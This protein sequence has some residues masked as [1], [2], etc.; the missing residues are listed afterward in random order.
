[1]LPQDETNY[2]M[3]NF[4]KETI[5]SDF[6]FS[7]LVINELEHKDIKIPKHWNLSENRARCI[8]SINKR[9]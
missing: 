8:F 9:I 3:I 7:N 1:M 6:V 4:V 2:K 5:R